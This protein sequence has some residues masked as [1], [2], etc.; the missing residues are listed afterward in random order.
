MQ[1]PAEALCR[2]EFH[3]A[4]SIRKQD[5]GAGDLAEAMDLEI[6]ARAA[7]DKLLDYDWPDFLRP[8][9]DI[10]VLFDHI[11]PTSRGR[12]TGRGLLK[13]IQSSGYD[14]SDQG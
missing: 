4:R 2:T 5:P 3:L 7:L 6:K 11:Q 9:D 12:W 8:V 1:W 13:Y 10:M 14:S